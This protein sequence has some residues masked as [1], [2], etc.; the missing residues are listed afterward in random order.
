MVVGAAGA[1]RLSSTVSGQ[2][3]MLAGTD[4]LSD[5]DAAHATYALAICTERNWRQARCG[6][7]E[8]GML[9]DVVMGPA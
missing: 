2:S 1:K 6:L 3:G 8:I 4:T 7:A 9:R 5:D